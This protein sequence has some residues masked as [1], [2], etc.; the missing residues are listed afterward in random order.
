[1]T[2]DGAATI[3]VIAIFLPVAFMSGVIGRFFLQF[4]VALSVAVAI[5]SMS[6]AS[7][8]Q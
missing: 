5:S 2:D 4:G 6:F 1:M 3:A 7:Y 8:A